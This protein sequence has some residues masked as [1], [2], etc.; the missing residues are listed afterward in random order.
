GRAGQP[1]RR[2]PVPQPRPPPT[3]GDP[4]DQARMKRTSRKNARALGRGD[5]RVPDVLAP[6]PS[7]PSRCSTRSNALYDR[8]ATEHGPPDRTPEE[9]PNLLVRQGP[10]SSERVERSA[11]LIADQRCVGARWIK[12]TTPR[13]RWSEAIL[14]AWEDLNL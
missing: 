6:G 8:C 11:K 1:R 3:L 10:T 13:F 9:P 5:P 2:A 7:G 12:T 4:R 14:W